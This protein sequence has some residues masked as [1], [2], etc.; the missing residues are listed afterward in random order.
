MVEHASSLGSGV[1]ESGLGSTGSQ[2]YRAVVC[3]LLSS[4]ADIAMDKIFN[5]VKLSSRG[6]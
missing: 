1:V 5:R 6:S 3:E 4:A 2:N